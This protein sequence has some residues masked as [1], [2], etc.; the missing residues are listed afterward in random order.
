LRGAWLASRGTGEDLGLRANSLEA[1]LRSDPG[2]PRT[3]RELSVTYLWLG[4]DRTAGRL[5]LASRALRTAEAGLKVTPDHSG[6]WEVKGIALTW[7]GRRPEAWV[8][9]ERAKELAP[10][11]AARKGAVKPAKAPLTRKGQ[12]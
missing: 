4:E 3:Y 9:L 11:K 5:L 12:K 2:N 8:A 7:L 6:L 10:W 1:A